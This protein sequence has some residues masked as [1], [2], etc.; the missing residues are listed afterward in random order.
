[1]KKCQCCGWIDIPGGTSAC[2]MCGESSWI[3]TDDTPLE[4]TAPE[5]KPKKA[6]S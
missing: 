4:T 3:R 6:K 1:M 5:E 2:P